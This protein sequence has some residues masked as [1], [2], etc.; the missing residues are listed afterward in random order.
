MKTAVIVIFVIQLILATWTVADVE[1][2][3][4]SMKGGR[5]S[6]PWPKLPCYEKTLHNSSAYCHGDFTVNVSRHHIIPINLLI[7]FWNKLILNEA[8]LST[9]ME[10]AWNSFIIQYRK[11]PTYD[12]SV[13]DLIKKIRDKQIVNDEDERPPESFD[14]LKEAWQWFGAN[15]M[16]GPNRRSDDPGNN[17]EGNAYVIVGNVTFYYMKDMNKFMGGYKS[18]T[19]LNDVEEMASKFAKVLSTTDKPYPLVASNWGLKDGKY[20]IDTNSV[21]LEELMEEEIELEIDGMGEN[22]NFVHL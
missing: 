10:T 9:G 21:S 8:H 22:E 18:T 7:A 5:E 6:S 16:I 3:D 15:L 1:K 2:C 14:F 19:T 12:K 13:E 4:L 11:F 17:F 20:Y